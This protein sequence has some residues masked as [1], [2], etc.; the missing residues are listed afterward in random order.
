[1]RVAPR[2]VRFFYIQAPPTV[3]ETWDTFNFPDFTPD[4]TEPM[5]ATSD[6]EAKAICGGTLEFTLTF[7]VQLFSFDSCAT[8]G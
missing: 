4:F 8:T 7:T 2:P 5:L 1:M 3:V 6:P